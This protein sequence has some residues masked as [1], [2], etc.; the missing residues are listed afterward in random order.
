MEKLRNKTLKLKSKKSTNF[1]RPI[2]QPIRMVTD[3]TQE[4]NFLVRFQVF[5]II[6]TQG[7]NA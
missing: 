7:R 3:V 4:F 1:L 6:N 2:V 5:V